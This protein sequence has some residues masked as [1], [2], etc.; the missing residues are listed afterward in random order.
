MQA[1]D[2]GGMTSSKRLGLTMVECLLATVV[3]AIVGLAMV[4][5]LSSG[6]ARFAYSESALRGV[7]LGE[8]LLEEAA[9][10]PYSGT[11]ASR[12]TWCMDDYNGFSDGPKDLADFTGNAYASGDQGFQRTV[13][14]TPSSVA[15]PQLASF[16]AAGKVLKVRVDAPDGE[17]WEVVRFVAEPLYP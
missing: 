2:T 15:V 14:V 6:R 10:R 7:R 11:G 5:V 4:F 13:E 3:L 9:A 17:S 16:V 12:S 1:T 8:H